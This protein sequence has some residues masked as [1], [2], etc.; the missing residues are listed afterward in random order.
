MLITLKAFVRLLLLPPSGPLLLALLGLVL[1]KWG[2]RTGQVLLTV[3]VVSLWLLST[4]VVAD[5]LIRLAERCPA[6]DLSK[7]LHAG[8]IVVLG[9]GERRDSAPEY[10]GP[11]ADGE[12]LERLTYAAY[13]QRCTGLPVLVTGTRSEATTMRE[14]LERNFGIHA[15]WVEAQSRDTFENA[16]FSARMLRAEGIERIVLVTSAAH[17]WRAAREFEGAGM[18]VT[19][20]PAVLWAR[21]EEGVFRYVP[22]VSAMRHSHAALYELAGEPV[23][24]F[25]AVTHLR[26][27]HPNIPSSVTWGG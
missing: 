4:P 8:A 21:Q 22:S 10:G 12:L 14:S 16:S 20:A 18:A 1:L 5:V 6:L 27:Q 9:G 17:M 25:L 7:P 13:V 11:A 26:K 15:R 3:G 24:E 2:R 23:R 19:P